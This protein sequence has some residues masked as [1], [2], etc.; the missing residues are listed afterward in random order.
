MYKY[1]IE[2][3]NKT[4]RIINA[5]YTE[6]KDGWLLFF[7]RSTGLPTLVCACSIHS[8]MDAVIIQI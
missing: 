1:R 3:D 7:I 8:T 4:F 5:D 2:F 6:I